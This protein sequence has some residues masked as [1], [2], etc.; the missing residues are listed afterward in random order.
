MSHNESIADRSDE[1]TSKTKTFQKIKDNA[2]TVAIFGV[3]FGVTA[4]STFYSVKTLQLNYLSA[5]LNL[6]VVQAA[7]KQ[8]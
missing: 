7:A 4:V 8:V 5:K 2:P 3:A 1:P 6:E